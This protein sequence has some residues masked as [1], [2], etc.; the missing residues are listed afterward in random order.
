MFMLFT[1]RVFGTP[2][3]TLWPGVTELKEYKTNFPKWKP[4]QLSKVLPSLDE[5]GIDLLEVS[6]VIFFRSMAYG[7][8]NLKY[9]FRF[10]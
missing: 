8:N 1:D 6:E 10:E 3:E 9:Y 5:N 2:N 4:Q 7:L